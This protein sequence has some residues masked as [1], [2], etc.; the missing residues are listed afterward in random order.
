MTTYVENDEWCT[1]TSRESRDRFEHTVFSTWSLPIC[2]QVSNYS[3]TTNSGRLTRYTQQGSD[4][5]LAPET[6]CS[7]AEGHQMRRRST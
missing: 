7:L 2:T 6:V 4:N 1:V 5:S 3:T